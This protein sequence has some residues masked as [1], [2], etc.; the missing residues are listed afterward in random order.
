[1]TGTPSDPSSATSLAVTV[2]GADIAYYKYKVGAAASTT[3]S[4]S[5]GY[6][7]EVVRTTNITSSVLV[8]T[9]ASLTL[10]VW[11][12]DTAGNYQALAD[13]TD[14]TWTKDT[15]APTAAAV[16]LGGA[17]SDPSK[18]VVLDVDV[19]GG[20]STHYKY[21]VGLAS[22]TTCSSATGYSAEIAIASHIVDDVSLL[23]DT[24]LK[25]CVITRDTA[26]NW[27]SVS[28]AESYT[29][30]KDTTAPT[31]TLSGT[32][33]SLSNATT[34]DITVSDSD[35]YEY[36]Y[37]VTT[38]ANCVGASYSAYRLKSVHI[39]DTLGS[40]D[41]YRVCVISRDEVTNEQATATEY[42]WSKDTTAPNAA[43]LTL[44]G[45]PASPSNTTTLGVTVN[46][47]DI[48]YYKYKVGA[49]A[50]TTCS[51][52]T[53]Y[54]AEV[55]RTTGITS[56]ISG[57]ADASLTLCVWGRDSAGNYQALADATTYT[58][59]KDTTA[60]TAAAVTLSGV[61]TDPSQDIVLNVA[62]SGG[63]ST[64][65]KYKVGLASTTT[66][67]DSSGY[68]AEVAVASNIVDNISS[69]A[70]S[71][72]K[73]CVITRD[74]A[75]NWMSVASG[76]SYSWFKDAHDPTPGNSG[77]ITA[78]NVDLNTMTLNW[79]KA[80]DVDSAT[81]QASLTYKVYKST[82]NNLSTVAAM[83]SCE[84][85]ATC[86]VLQ[87][88]TANINT[89][90]VSSLTSNTV[91][92]FN[93]IVKDNIGRQSAYT[94][95]SQRT[96]PAAH[97]AYKDVTNS[98]IKYATNSSGSF[99][100]SIAESLAN[101]NISLDLDSNNKA[102]IS[103]VATDDL[104]YVTNK[105]GSWVSTLVDSNY[106]LDN[107]SIATDSANNP[108]ISYFRFD[109]NKDWKY[110]Y[111][112]GTSWL[113]TPENIFNGNG[114][115]QKGFYSSIVLDSNNKVQAV[116]H[117]QDVYDLVYNT[118]AG[119]SF[120]NNNLVDLDDNNVAGA[121]DVGRY[122]SITRDSSNNL[123]VSYYDLTNGNLKYIKRTSGTWGSASI[124]DS[125]GDVGQY[126]G[127]AVTTNGYVH[128]V[129]HDVT[130]LDLKYACYNGSSWTVS[131]IDS[132]GDV[133]KYASIV[134]DQ[135]N[136]VHVSYYDLTNANLKYAKGSC[137]GTW[138]TSIVDSTGDVGQ[139]T[140]IKVER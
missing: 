104:R 138:T 10:C 72:L 88:F 133:G 59:T 101:A 12:R 61:P 122:T 94:M 2:N 47:A 123:Y 70:D 64:H 75:S 3:C 8:L 23:A 41:T 91:Y 78:S 130:N 32:P 132:T 1:L 56:S 136:L 80:T 55:V 53:S 89:L 22:T 18:E 83:E 95:F 62:V 6:S 121:A 74:A 54:S 31:A 96:A 115:K 120:A 48:A 92:Y 28:A 98:R 11:G 131:T 14:Y 69:L 67:T 43:A 17:P 9:D 76:K 27:M 51:S 13:A 114:G 50:S 42:S 24:T 84:T 20:G 57:L 117:D 108:H 49:A 137:G 35:T 68:S 86:T 128:I 5:T 106:I 116:G 112:N 34:L 105:S 79:T 52:S 33:S 66:C 126:T 19:S 45:T 63:G 4:S 139:W 107:T 7:S 81:P 36:K 39:T 134:S 109:S 125:T 21:K 65:Y 97:I 77:T 25:I 15:T 102:H 93:V 99:V 38:A 85:G 58:W 44:T 140:S 100:T 135:G 29:W 119:G 16:T 82:T 113:G 110:Q 40:D 127:I 87:S 46:G 60:P 30:E 103:Y 71:T 124:I 37:A 90:N 129:Y 73:L 111:H 26:G 118:N